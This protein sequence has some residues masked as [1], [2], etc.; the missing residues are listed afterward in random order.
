MS[1]TERLGVLRV[2]GVHGGEFDAEGRGLAVRISAQDQPMIDLLMTAEHGLAARGINISSLAPHE[3][4]SLPAD[5]FELGANPDS[6]YQLTFVLPGSGKLPLH[7]EH[8][9]AS[10][11][12]ETLQTVVA[13]ATGSPS[14]PRDRLQ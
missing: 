1:G 13:G 12:L 6:T 7:L 3:S 11:L 10:Q 2:T 9:T 8:S 14:I 4:F 5:K